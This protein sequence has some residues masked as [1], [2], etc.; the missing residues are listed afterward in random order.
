MLR[1]VIERFGLLN[2]VYWEGY[3]RS[4]NVNGRTREEATEVTESVLSVE[5]V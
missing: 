1:L 5:R 3:I 4:V 2:A